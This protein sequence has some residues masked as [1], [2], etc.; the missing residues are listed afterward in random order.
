MLTLIHHKKD[1]LTVTHVFAPEISIQNQEKTNKNI[2]SILTIYMYDTINN[3]KAI[4]H[5]RTQFNTKL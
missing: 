4:I 1:N 2:S 3:H 5:I